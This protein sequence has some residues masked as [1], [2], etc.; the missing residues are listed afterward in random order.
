M[1]RLDLA[2]LTSQGYGFQ[3]EVAWELERLGC[4]IVEVPITFVERTGGRSKMS[5]GIAVEALNNVLRWG[6]E[7]RFGKRRAK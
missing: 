3:V 2:A 1:T 6:W 7:L 5:V 4:P